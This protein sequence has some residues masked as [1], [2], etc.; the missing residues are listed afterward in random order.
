[1]EVLT[2]SASACDIL[3][4]LAHRRWRGAEQPEKILH[5]GAANSRPTTRHGSK[6]AKNEN[7]ISNYRDFHTNKYLPIFL[8]NIPKIA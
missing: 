1:V 3:N 4:I 5:G 7:D 2:S 6:E 8:K